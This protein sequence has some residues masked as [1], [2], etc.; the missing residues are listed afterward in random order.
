MGTHP[1]DD[2]TLDVD[3][4]LG[5]EPANALL[6][7]T[8][9]RGHGSVDE[10]VAEAL[11]IQAA[12]MRLARQGYEIVARHRDGREIA[13]PFGELDETLNLN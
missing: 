8:F 4:N 11:E 1:K 2:N 5:I 7:L 10:T 3:V 6:Q 13:L 9:R 12:F